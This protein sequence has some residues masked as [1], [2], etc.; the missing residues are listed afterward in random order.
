MERG[1]RL[2]DS[3]RYDESEP[4]CA[5]PWIWSAARIRGPSVAPAGTSASSSPSGSGASRR[6]SSSAAGWPWAAPGTPGAAGPPPLEPRER[7]RRAR[8]LVARR[9]RLAALDDSWPT[10][11]PRS[12][13]L[14]D[15]V[16]W[17]RAWMAIHA[18]D[19]ARPVRWP[20][21]TGRLLADRADA[22]GARDRPR[23][24][25]HPPLPGGPRRGGACARRRMAGRGAGA[26]RHRTSTACDWSA[27]TP[28]RHEQARAEAR[29]LLAGFEAG[30]A[31]SGGDL[32][33]EIAMD[34]A[35]CLGRD[36]ESAE[37][38]RRAYDVAAAVTLSRA[39][40]SSTP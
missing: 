1:V 30:G 12:R 6:S 32:D 26:R 35:Q 11:R 37:Q 18:G 29:C 16:L 23:A 3:G 22:P 5:R 13:D 15:L 4:S 31:R 28:G 8:P 27:S 2:S 21:R 10:T 24:G 40:P 38:A 17:P 9:R 14:L 7:V 36:P 19:L 25:G 34:V 39:S 33:I 20:R